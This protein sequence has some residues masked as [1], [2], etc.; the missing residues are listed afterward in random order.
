MSS[1]TD[2]SSQVGRNA[3]VV[4]LRIGLT[5]VLGCVLLALL[6]ALAVFGLGTL[7]SHKSP[8][9]EGE[10]ILF[11]SILCGLVVLVAVA[12]AGIWFGPVKRR[13]GSILRSFRPPSE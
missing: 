1:P 4:V 5:V 12:I 11:F 7:I 9:S 6:A 2:R 10:I 3:M 13:F 8:G